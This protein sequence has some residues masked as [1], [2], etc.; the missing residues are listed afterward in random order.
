MLLLETARPLVEL[1]DA[2][3]QEYNVERDRAEQDTK[4]FVS[5]MLAVGLVEASVFVAMAAEGPV[6]R[7]GLG[8]ADAS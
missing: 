2:V 6:G 7:E 8:A 4:Q 5:E 3:A 1:V